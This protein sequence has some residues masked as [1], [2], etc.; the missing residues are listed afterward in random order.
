MNLEK[1]LIDAGVNDFSVSLDSC[2]AET[3]DKMA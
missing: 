1:K 2:C 3:G